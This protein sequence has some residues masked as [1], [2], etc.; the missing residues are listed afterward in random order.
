MAF[1]NIS[2]GISWA[3]SDEKLTRLPEY[4]AF[5]GSPS[6]PADISVAELS[7][8]RRKERHTNTKRAPLLLALIDTIQA[9]TP[10]L[11]ILPNGDTLRKRTVLLRAATLGASRLMVLL[12]GK[13]I[14]DKSHV[15]LRTL[16]GVIPLESVGSD[17]LAWGKLQAGDLAVCEVEIGDLAFDVVGFEEDGADD[18]L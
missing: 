18:G 14:A 3:V 7:P 12:P 8:F 1:T 2:I 15:L 10:I 6:E 9:R 11:T 13:Q 4:W 16:L 5:F 17:E